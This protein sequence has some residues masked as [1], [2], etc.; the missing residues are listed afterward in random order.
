MSTSSVAG[1]V[2]A[3]LGLL[4]VAFLV[5]GDEEC[6]VSVRLRRLS[7]PWRRISMVPG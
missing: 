6:V 1:L 2:G 4:L 5:D 7:L 3:N